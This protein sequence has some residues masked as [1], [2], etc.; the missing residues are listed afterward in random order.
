M[1]NNQPLN[2]VRVLDLTNIIMGPFATQLLGDL[3]ADIIKVE[4][5]EGDLMRD[6]GI[7]KSEKMSSVF[8]GTN[9][10][11][12][13]IILNLKEKSHKLVLWKLIAKSDIFIHNMR[14]SKLDILGFSHKKILK[15]N[16]KIIFTALYGYGFGGNYFE[17]PAFDDIIQGLSGISGLYLSKDNKPSLVPT[18]IADKSIGLLAC[19]AVL[20]AYIKRLKT[21][22]G[23]CI[24]ISMFEGMVS[25]TMLEH[26]YGEIFSPPLDQAGYPRILNK[27]R[28]P[29]KTSD[30]YICI[31]P[32]TKKQWYKFFDVMN[33]IDLKKDNS[34]FSNMNKL[35]RVSKYYSII[36]K[37]VKNK[38]NEELVRILTAND[39][40]HGQ[41]NTL[42]S[43]KENLHLKETNF[44]RSFKHPTEGELV[45]PDTG[46]K[47]NSKSLPVT[48]H[49]PR[50]GEHT[51]EILKELDI[52]DNK[53]KKIVKEG[54]N[55]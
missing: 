24:E 37:S 25:Y 22:K 16:K 42:E 15:K 27:Y 2:G 46:I 53:I 34:F 1:V 47:L 11:K 55:E 31:L 10:N 12:R 49:Q 30:G 36:E 54:M 7:S 6:V 39:I 52:N 9:R 28:K 32:Y 18:L 38:K 44:F 8:L 29:F 13:S 41:V 43:L 33:L 4:S 40:P 20:A 21:N 5:P 19:S 26:Q 45:I 14:P 51:I 50:L 3:G 35:N 48:R 23:S 17:Q